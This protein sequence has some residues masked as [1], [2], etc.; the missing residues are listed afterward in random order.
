M[1]SLEPTDIE[2]VEQNHE[3][4]YDNDFECKICH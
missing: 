3:Y 1:A 4:D 2:S